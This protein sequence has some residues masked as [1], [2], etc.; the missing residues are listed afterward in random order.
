VNS[1]FDAYGDQ[2]TAGTQTYSYDA[3]G[4]VMS[5]AGSGQGYAFSYQGASQA[6]ASDGVYDY[7]WDPSGTSLVGIEGAGSGSGGSGEL[8]LANQHGDVVG[9]F[10]ASGTGVKG[11]RTYDPWGTVLTSTGT[12]TGNLGYQSGWTDTTTGK[13][14]MGARWYSPA[15]GNFTSRDT[16]QVAQS[17]A[18][19]AANPFGYATDNPLSNVDRSGHLTVVNGSGL[20]LQ[21]AAVQQAAAQAAATAAPNLSALEE[22]VSAAQSALGSLGDLAHSGADL[23]HAGLD[24][25][26]GNDSGARAEYEAALSRAKQA[27]AQAL[28]AVNKAVAAART[29]TINAIDAIEAKTLA[30]ERSFTTALA[31][32]KKKLV[33][34]AE[35]VVTKTVAAGSRVYHAVTT[36]AKEGAKAV[37]HAVG[38]AANV[39]TRAATATASFV[40]NHAAAIASIATSVAVMVGCEA[41]VGVATAGT[42]TEGCA[43]VAGA[44]G[45]AVGYAVN[46]A[47]HGG[48]SWSGLGKATLT[49]AVAGLALGGLGALGGTIGKGLVGGLLASGEDVADSAIS[50]AVDEAGASAAGDGSAVAGGGDTVTAQAGGDATEG[51][52]AGAGDTSAA[53]TSAGDTGA[54]SDTGNSNATEGDAGT[55]TEGMHG[56]F[57]R[58]GYPA[59][60]DLPQKVEES[61]ELWGQSPRNNLGSGVPRVKAYR[62][63]LP[64]NAPKGSFEFYTPVAPRSAGDGAPPDEA[65]WFEGDPG[66]RSFSIDGT[67]WAAIP[68]TITRILGE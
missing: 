46:A 19:G 67:D 60:R 23:L 36:Y 18:S 62:G 59:A 13:V 37:V 14:A 9:Q 66:V 64:T 40:K 38:T 49:G 27:L 61:G 11:S 54:S 1:S 35:T 48:F 16:A 25:L 39:V 32:A 51:T 8:A 56:P 33:A 47:Q 21:Q 17:P 42:A 3:L 53:D 65:V 55:A 6:M 34:A 22:G 68:A 57:Y 15:T 63:S 28:S 26:T 12:V 43:A 52:T 41:T 45:S 58:R 4:R 10:T 50:G 7:T 20:T 2:V 29:E 24:W 44:A 30:A 31:D 5:D